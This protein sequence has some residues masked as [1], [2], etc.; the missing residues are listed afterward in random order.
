M[1]DIVTPIIDGE[2]INHEIDVDGL[3]DAIDEVESDMDIIID[4]EL[5]TTQDIID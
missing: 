3:I 1:R 5:P 2:I 4:G